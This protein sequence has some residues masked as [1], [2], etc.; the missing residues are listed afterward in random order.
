MYGRAEAIIGGG[1][2]FGDGSTC[3]DCRELPFFWREA[4]NTVLRA[5]WHAEASAKLL[6][7]CVPVHLVFLTPTTVGLLCFAHLGQAGPANASISVN[8]QLQKLFDSFLPIY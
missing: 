4:A 7:T 1:G 5:L 8:I 3:S 6:K 2:L